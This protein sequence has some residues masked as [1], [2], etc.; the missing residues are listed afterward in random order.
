MMAVLSQASLEF[1]S[2]S[3]CLGERLPALYTTADAHDHFRNS[4]QI[5][6]PSHF[7]ALANY[8]VDHQIVLNYVLVKVY[9]I[10]RREDMK[11]LL[12]Y[13]MQDVSVMVGAGSLTGALVNL[14]FSVATG[15][16]APQTVAI[17]AAAGGFVGGRFLS[18]KLRR[19][20]HG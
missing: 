11:S 16:P 1:A 17:I 15:S 9:P 7:A 12:H 3:N 14:M 8:S 2:V 13:D 10:V 18:A 4:G 19:S 5:I 20:R 6:S